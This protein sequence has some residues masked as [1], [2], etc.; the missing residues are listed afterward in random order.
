MSVEPE[1]S[2]PRALGLVAAGANL[3]V[4]ATGAEKTTKKKEGSFQ[5]DR[6]LLQAVVATGAGGWYGRVK[7]V[8]V[9]RMVMVRCIVR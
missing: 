2:R 4:V 3:D 9:V 1:R 7:L 5:N 6:S 8:R